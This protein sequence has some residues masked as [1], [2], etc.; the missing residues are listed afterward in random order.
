[1]QQ[2]ILL[3]DIKH[4]KNAPKFALFNLGFRPFFLLA[5]IFSI[6]SLSKWMHLYLGNQ[7]LAMLYVSASQWH[8]HEMLYG[9]ALAVIAGFLLTAVKNW[10]GLATLQGK[11]LMALVLCWASARAVMLA[12][13]DWV[14]V[15]ALFDMAFNLGL[16]VAITR[17]IV[18]VKQ[19]RQLGVLAKVMLLSIGNAAYYAAVLGLWSHGASVSI[20]IG[21][22][23]TVS[24]VLVISRR[25]LP[26][27]IERGV[28]EKVTLKQHKWADVSIMVFLVL[29]LLNLL[30]YQHA[31]TNI[32]LGT[33]MFL[34]NG[35]RLVH[36]HTKGIWKVPL[37]WSFYSGLWLVNLGFLWFAFSY[38]MP[39]VSLILAIHL[40]AIGG[41]GLITLS[42]MARVS[43]G[44]TGRNIHEPPA[45]M[46]YAFGLLIIGALVRAVLP[47]LAQQ[48]YS[49][50]V[51]L[52][53][54]C[55]LI[56]FAMFVVSYYRTLTQPRIDGQAG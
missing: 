41:I 24:L 34:V 13:P 51:I 22:F 32:A 38:F 29:I 17:P 35:F 49:L 54:V 9:Y 14:W 27:F 48:H 55:W 5:A 26:M 46:R 39:S 3:N 56:G 28:A 18:K 47:L 2:H 1:M 31:T 30:F 43:L 37:L 4:P 33:L 23:L 19:W 7:S 50:W 16:A 25:V 44:H 10:T 15:A 20:Y 52:A 11:P 40:W 8:A 21:L 53:Y 6:I 45:T 12:K 42:M 36:W